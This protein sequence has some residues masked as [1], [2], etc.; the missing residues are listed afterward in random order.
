MDVRLR[1][2][3]MMLRSR[4]PTQSRKDYL[5]GLRENVSFAL[6]GFTSFRLK[7]FLKRKLVRNEYTP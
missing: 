1:P 4:R 5:I 2:L 6:F 3:V 7:R